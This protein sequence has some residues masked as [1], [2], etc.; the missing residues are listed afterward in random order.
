[1]KEE[2]S[3]PV[4][5]YKGTWKLYGSSIPHVSPEKDSYFSLISAM[6]KRCP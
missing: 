6:S 4:P 1:L 2:Q 5:L 3:P